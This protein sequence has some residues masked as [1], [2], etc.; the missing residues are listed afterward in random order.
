MEA[1]RRSQVVEQQENLGKA[2]ACL[3]DSL[4]GLENRLAKV[5]RQPTLQC[6]ED[7]ERGVL[8]ELA[9]DLAIDVEKL[10]ALHQMVDSI[11]DRLE[12]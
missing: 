11:T 7:T 5:L 8:V 12:L 2:I 1:A 3:D 6:K 9:N 4:K 10:I